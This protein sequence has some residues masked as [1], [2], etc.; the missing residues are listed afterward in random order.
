MSSR[1]EPTRSDCRGR[2]VLVSSG[3]SHFE[4]RT[5]RSIS[6]GRFH[7]LG[8][9]P[10]AGGT[11]FALYSKHATEVFLLL[12]DTATGEP[13][14]VIRLEHRTR[15]VFHALVAG[16]RPGQLYGYRVRGPYDPAR[17]H[18]F[19]E[20]KLLVDPYA[21][22]LTGKPRN[23]A[24]LLLGY[25][26]TSPDRDLSYD[27]RDNVHLVP[28]AIV[29]D[30]AF[31]WQGDAPPAI[32]FEQMVIYEVHLKG[33]TGHP[34]SKVS[35]PGTYLG[36]IEKIPHLVDLGVNVVELLP[37][38]ERMVG[39]FL[40][41]RGLTNYWGYDTLG[42][43]AA[44]SAYRASARPGAEV[45]EMK[46]LVRALHRHGIEV[47]LDVVY[48]HTAEGSELGPTV[49]LRG[50][51]NATY[52]AL[53]GSPDQPRRHYMNWAGCGN[54][55]NLGDP[56]V[57]RF[58]MDSLR[59]WADVMHVDGFRFDLASVLGRTQGA[60]KQT[61]SF[62]DV[63]A[64]DPTLSRI[65]LI[66]EPWDLATYE[67]GNF[68]VDWSEWNGRFRDTVRKF[69]KGEPGLVPDLARR[70]AGSSDL[71]SDDGRHP[72]NTIN[73]VTCHDGFPLADLVSYNGKINAA[74]LEDNRDGCDDNASWNSGAEGPTDDAAILALR[75]QRSKNLMC[76]LL[77]SAGTPMVLAGDELLRSQGG[78]N[79]AYCQDNEISWI[80][81]SLRET[82][83][84]FFQFVK[85][86][87]AFTRRYP[88]F[89]RKTFFSGADLNRDTHL[90]LRWYGFDLDEPRWGDQE[91]RT[92]AYLL[93][94]AEGSVVG[95]Y[96]VFVIFNASWHHVTVRIPPTVGPRRWH[97]V[98]DTSQAA[99]EDFLVDSDQ[100]VM[101]PADHYLA[102][103]RSSIVL[104][105]RA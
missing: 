58:V 96:L 85:H 76:Q 2:A 63:I 100:I 38:H 65:K 67:V 30:D 32:P 43:F 56:H 102:S 31:D 75:R 103:P 54:S 19:N 26:A 41:E 61:A 50:V 93:D 57:I 8:A 74:N 16:V 37:L 71:Y 82:N 36:F 59:Y 83:A 80:D 47:V 66:A 13:T 15:F 53:T 48:N 88:A 27:T 17:G 84:D 22:A 78:N 49:S 77:F 33:F 12:F 55:L 91:L 28:K 46:Q 105:A 25:D 101:D 94:G 24:N 7:P 9:T 90:D 45:D 79:N 97:R 40:T 35:S 42:F 87:I 95:D 70:I 29:I 11:N 86:V 6:A 99:G 44:E 89:Q 64:Q 21:K 4:T 60:F 5:S 98:I 62:F 73:F 81:W 39:D 20:H 69:E 104:L 68:P 72:Y 34:S 52:Y 10:E 51:D 92:I 18:R 3:V 1:A 14:D 23:E